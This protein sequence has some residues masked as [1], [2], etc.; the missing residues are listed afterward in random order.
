MRN[1]KGFSLVELLVVIAIMGIFLGS[2][3]AVFGLIQSGNMKN[4]TKTITSGMQ[5]TRT[6]TMT[7]NLTGEW[8]LRGYFDDGVFCMDQVK[9]VKVKNADDTTTDVPT[10]LTTQMKKCTMTYTDGNEAKGEISEFK[11]YYNASTGAVKSFSYTPVGAGAVAV[12]MTAKS[13]GTVTFTSGSN[14]SK[15]NVYFMT[16]KYEID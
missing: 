4:V 13:S 12:D 6:N 9:V 3:F 14:V 10:I 2:S 8:Y 15:V 1:N 7:Q 5:E 16:G 11:I